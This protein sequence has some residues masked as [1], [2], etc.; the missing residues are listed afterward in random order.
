[1]GAVRRFAIAGLV[2]V[3]FV[4][5]AAP[6]PQLQRLVERTVDKNIRFYHSV[7]KQ[8][9][10]GCSQG[11]TFII[12][13][14]PWTG[15]KRTITLNEYEAPGST[16]AVIIMPPTGG[17]NV[18]DQYWGN[19]LCS[20]GI[21][22]VIVSSFELFPENGV[23]L[24]MYDIEAL[25]SL[26]AIRQTAEYLERSGAKTI[27]LLGTSL[28][29]IQG[30]FGIMVDD[31]INTATLIV[32]GLGLA[33][34]AAASQEPEQVKLREIRMKMW[35]LDQTQYAEKLRRAVHVDAVPYADDPTLAQRKKVLSIVAEG[36]TYVPTS[37]QMRLYRVWGEQP[38]IEMKRSHISTV[39]RSA[40]LHAHDVATFFDENLR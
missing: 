7:E 34:I 16:R 28:G 14:E 36:D 11:R 13:K 25:R 39:M 5:Q 19:L 6:S 15:A 24:K 30:A 1:M 37:N 18:V 3:S 35:K 12:G 27:G 29:A 17:E 23:D 22:A 31:R 20:K 38:L 26:A 2:F 33:Q 21:R 32:G 40:I 4:A 9:F 10:K 8:S